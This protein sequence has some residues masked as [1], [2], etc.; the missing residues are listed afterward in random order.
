[1]NDDIGYNRK[2]LRF[3]SSEPESDQRKKIPIPLFQN[4]YPED[5]DLI[6]LIPS[7]KINIGNKP[8]FKVVND[9]IRIKELIPKA[10]DIINEK[11]FAWINGTLFFN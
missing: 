6:D 10:I 11:P 2:F 4:E 8:L 5:A 3:G 7:E 1:M 9:E